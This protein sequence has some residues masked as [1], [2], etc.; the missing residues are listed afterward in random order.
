[1]RVYLTLAGL[2]LSTSALSKPEDFPEIKCFPRV[3]MLRAIVTSV[4]E[5]H[6][7]IVAFDGDKG[8]AILD[9][10]NQLEPKSN[11]PGDNL[12]GAVHEDGSTTFFIFD[13]EGDALCGPIMLSR[14]TALLVES[15]GDG[16]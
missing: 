2:L 6:G 9:A 8:K 15:A 13:R 1:M 12:V 3:D 7:T 10:I 4:A 11:F 14:E 5:V 16:L